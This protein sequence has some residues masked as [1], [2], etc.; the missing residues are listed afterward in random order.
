LRTGILSSVF[1]PGM[2]AIALP[3]GLLLV[4]GC[5]HDEPTPL[6]HAQSNF[7]SGQWGQTIA[8]CDDLIAKNPQDAGAYLLR[9]RARQCSGQLDLALSDLTTAISINPMD[10]EAYYQRAGVYRALGKNDLKFDDDKKA[11]ELDRAYLESAE[12]DRERFDAPVI[13]RT[14]NSD[15]VG[16]GA[17]AGKDET[18]ELGGVDSEIDKDLPKRTSITETLFG[19]TSGMPDPANQNPGKSRIKRGKAA[20]PLAASTPTTPGDK[21]D[22]GASG[23]FG[24]VG[25][26]GIGGIGGAPAANPPAAALPDNRPVGRDVAEQ[27]PPAGRGRQAFNRREQVI[28]G[29]PRPAGADAPAAAAPVSRSLNPYNPQAALNPLARQQLQLPPQGR[30]ATVGS[31]YYVPPYGPTGGSAAP[32]TTGTP[33]TPIF[34]Q[35]PGLREDG[36]HGY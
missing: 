19:G 15:T 5:G 10:P 34:P 31:P 20:G 25:L 2:W 11:R 9:G 32:R 35:P 12:I 13:S 4:V 24:G 23:V 36:G 7:D 30:A 6:Q 21:A 8:A 28:P 17:V 18:T 3:L 29:M 26:T 22:P 27:K 16:D 1:A 33:P 14:P